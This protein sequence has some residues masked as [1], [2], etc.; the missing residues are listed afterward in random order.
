MGRSVSYATGSVIKAYI[1]VSYIECEFDWM[2]FVGDIRSRVKSMWKSFDNCNEWLDREDQAILENNLAYIGVSEYCGLACL[3][4]VPK[5]THDQYGNC[6][7]TQLSEPWCLRIAE[8]FEKTFSEYRK[9]A[10]ASN[11]E[12]FYERVYGEVT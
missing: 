1:D 12:A 11:G 5:D 3:W 8:K 7:G 4:L 6:Q 2:D 10:T 9:I